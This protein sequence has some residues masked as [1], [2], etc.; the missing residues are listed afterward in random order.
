[1]GFDNIREVTGT[2]GNGFRQFS[3]GDRHLG[4][5]STWEEQGPKKTV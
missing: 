4:G 2:W 3:G 1:M 5:T